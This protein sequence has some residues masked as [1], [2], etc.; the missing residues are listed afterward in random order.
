VTDLPFLLLLIASWGLMTIIGNILLKL[1]LRMI[2]I[3]YEIG[4]AVTGTVPVAG[5]SV[6][7]PNRLFHGIDYQGSICGV[8]GDVKNLDKL[9]YPNKDKNTSSILNGTMSTEQVPSSMGICVSDC[10]A[11]SQFDLGCSLMFLRP[12]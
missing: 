6:G 1:N 4:L 7:D 2:G 9:Y 8:D 3:W 11:I 12:F 5:L 10:P